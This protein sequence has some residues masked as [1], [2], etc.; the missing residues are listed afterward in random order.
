MSFTDE[1][2]QE[3]ARLPGNELAELSALIRMDGSL[4]IINKELALKVR[5][6]H[7]GLARKTYSLIKEK[8]SLQIQIIVRKDPY[9]FGNHN[10]YELIISPQ[11]GLNSFL[12]Q[13]GLIDQEHKPLFRIKERFIKERSDQRAYLRGAF[14]GGGSVNSPNSEYHL[15]FRCEHQEF[16]ED[17]VGLLANFGLV[18][19]LSQNHNKHIVYLK[20]F[21]DIITVLNIIGAHQALLKMEDK[22]ILKDIKNSINRK[23]NCETANLDKTVRAATRQRADIELIEKKWGLASL[24]NG[25]QEIALLRKNN[26]YANLSELGQM[27]TPV[28]S[29]SGVNHRMRRIKKI[30]DQIRS[31]HRWI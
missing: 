10:I 14:L 11:P 22:Y 7:G 20:S 31:D 16:A 30:A 18:A 3:I 1:V 12:Y 26:P 13:L 4:Q 25:L 9:F 17:L 5:I 15:E 8:F 21:E 2:K 19:H 24:S 23:V 28:L 6:D 29:K 27:L